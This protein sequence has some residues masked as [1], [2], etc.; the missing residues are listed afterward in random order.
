MWKLWLVEKS[1]LTNISEQGLI[2]MQMEKLN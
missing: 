2:G 1:L